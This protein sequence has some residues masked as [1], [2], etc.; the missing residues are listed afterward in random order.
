[1][2][3]LARSLPSGARTPVAPSPC[4]PCCTARAAWRV[5]RLRETQAQISS[6]PHSASRLPARRASRASSSLRTRSCWRWCSSAQAVSATRPTCRRPCGGESGRGTPGCGSTTPEARR[7]RTAPCWGGRAAGRVRG[8]RIPGRARPRAVRRARPV[9]GAGRGWQSTVARAL[10]ADRDTAHRARGARC[11]LGRR[12]HP[13]PDHSRG[14][15]LPAACATRRGR[16]GAGPRPQTLESEPEVSRQLGALFLFCIIDTLGF[17]I[18]IPLVPYMA[19]RFGTAPA[20]ITPILGSYSLC[21]LL[22]APFWGRLSDRYGRRPILMS[23]L[24]GACVSYVLLGC[25]RNI[26]WLLA[27]RMLAG[28][29]AGN[30]A[31]AFAYASDVSAPQ[32]RAA[33]LGLIGAA[34]GIGF[35]LGPPLGGLLAGED[36]AGADFVAPAVVSTCLSLFAILLVR[37][38][39]PESNPAAKRRQHPDEPR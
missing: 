1:M 31:A 28:F 19:D 33:T 38:V 29:M 24:G 9:R 23:S 21:Q 25:A 34:I 15:R 3:R 14:A 13:Q 8:G 37:W 35:A 20:F 30:I 4:A 18:L 17:G 32:Q 10:A 36:P 6:P 7:P 39:L 16:V 11:R 26:W 2:N 22:A 12:P 27:S 5:L